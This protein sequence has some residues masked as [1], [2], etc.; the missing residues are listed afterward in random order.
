M[1]M[2]DPYLYSEGN[3][4]EDEFRPEPEFFGVVPANRSEDSESGFISPGQVTFAQRLVLEI[5]EKLDLLERLFARTNKLGADDVERL[6]LRPLANQKP[7]GKVIEGVFDGE[8]M[9]GADGK[10]YVVPPNYA[11]KSKLVEGDILKLTVTDD[12]QFIY[13]QI[14][15]I[16]RQRIICLLARDEVTGDY[17]AIADGKKWQVLGASVTFFRAEPGDDV[18]VLVPK[19]APSRWAAMENAMKKTEAA[20]PPKHGGRRAN[21]E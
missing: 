7:R 3:G 4:N 21:V 15:P 19:N 17:V 14:G 11:S 18:I 8:H 10:Q 6:L 1:D 20:L 13:K 16:E 12:G 2:I 5:R 9:M